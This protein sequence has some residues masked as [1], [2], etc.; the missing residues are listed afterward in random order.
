MSDLGCQDL[1]LGKYCCP[2]PAAAPGGKNATT[3][4]CCDTNPNP[5]PAQSSVG[6]SSSSAAMMSSMAVLLAGLFMAL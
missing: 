4:V 1:G 3:N 6:D 2:Q 5:E